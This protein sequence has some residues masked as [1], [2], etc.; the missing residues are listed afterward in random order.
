MFQKDNILVGIGLGLA[1]PFVGYALFLTFFE[2]MESA[3]LMS[4]ENMSSNFKL[5][6]VALVAIALNLIP[7]AIYNKKRFIDTMRGFVFPTLV[8]VIAW[9]LIY[10]RHLI[11]S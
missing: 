1:I 10:G 4:S 11:S 3:G 7:L 2:Q 8:Y 9:F 6:T 5:R